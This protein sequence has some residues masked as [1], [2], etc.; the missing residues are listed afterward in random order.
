MTLPG[1][2][3]RLVELQARWH[4]ATCIITRSDPDTEPVL[5]PNTGTYTPPDPVTVYSGACLVTPEGSDRV[6]QF[7]E[8]PVP[9]RRYTVSI[10]DLTADVRVGDT[11]WITVS[12]DP[13]LTGDA[14]Y[15]DTYI[16]GY[17]VGQA[18]VVLDVPKS[19]LA[20]VRRL[21]AEEI[22]D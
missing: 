10:S 6:E 5:D 19:E 8:Q 11:I 15:S 21:R 13:L 7:G 4:T 20:T 9:L 3:A 14:A 22:L 18:L 2:S 12:H 16:G 17:L 1:P